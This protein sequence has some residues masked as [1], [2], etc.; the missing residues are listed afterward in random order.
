MTGKSLGTA[1]PF[2]E[3]WHLSDWNEA[4]LRRFFTAPSG[5]SG[6][7]SRLYVTAEELKRAVGSTL[8][9]DQ[10]RD[11]FISMLRTTIRGRSLGKDADG[12]ASNWD[13][14]KPTAPPFL[15]HLLFT[16]MIA[17]DL[18]EELQDLGNYR[19]RLTRALGSGTNHGLERLKI[20]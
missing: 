9:A 3:D 12:R 18:S 13:S 1:L 5:E 4:L 11:S 17:N 7:I 19:L 2:P 14:S 20:L 10:V 6:P 15:A 16:C 8:S